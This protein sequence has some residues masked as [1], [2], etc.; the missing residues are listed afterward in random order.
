MKQTAQGELLDIIVHL[1]KL[2]TAYDSAGFVI[3]NSLEQIDENAEDFAKTLRPQLIDT[4]N[5]VY[6]LLKR[7]ESL[8]AYENMR[9][10]ALTNDS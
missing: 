3:K 4:A 8:P 7:L 6:E 5:G 10:N 2:L 1:R 9:K